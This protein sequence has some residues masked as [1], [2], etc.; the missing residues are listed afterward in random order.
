MKQSILALILI[1]SWPSGSESQTEESS[2]FSFFPT[3]TQ[4]PPLFANHEEPRMGLQQDIGSSNMT[5][6]VGNITDIVQYAH[7]GD[8]VRWG[9]DFF[10]YALS[11][12]YRGY[13]L[14]IAAADGF[15]G[16]HITYNNNSPW[17]FRFRALHYSAHLVDGH[18][19][20]DNLTWKDGLIPFP[21]SR[22]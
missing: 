18:Y 17:S 20:S 21:F 16:M 15:F 5:V 3:N 9:A 10:V 2:R 4:F 12:D 13:R 6:A 14:K 8:T 7:A 11:D 22:N 19:D 1:L